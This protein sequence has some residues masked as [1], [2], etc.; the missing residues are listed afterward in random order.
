MKTRNIGLLA[1]LIVLSTTACKD[2]PFRDLAPKERSLEIIKFKQ[3]EYKE[4]VMTMFSKSNETDELPFAGEFIL[5]PSLA[6][7]SGQSPYIELSDG[8]L[9]I[10]W[11]WER[12]YY[13]GEEAIIDLKWKD[14]TYPSYDGDSWP[15]ASWPKERLLADS[16]VA[17]YYVT[18][19]QQ[20]EK[21][22]HGENSTH[23][24]VHIIRISE[25][26]WAEY[27]DFWKKEMLQRIAHNDSL[28]EVYPP[29]LC[30]MIEEG[31]LDKYSSK[32]DISKRY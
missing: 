4:F 17:E 23:Q 3:P 1:T 9:L 5:P 11:R 32:V 24:S 7:Y 25:K 22:L 2:E 10:N 15:V 30:R 13:P 19:S 29:V 6:N 31:K 14:A 18:S 26:D 8:Y 12:M 21:Y 28:Y 16:P 20:M 27:D